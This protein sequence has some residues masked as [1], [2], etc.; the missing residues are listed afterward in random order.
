MMRDAFKNWASIDLEK[1]CTRITKGGTPTTYG[2]NFLKEGINFIKV[3]N[4]KNGAVDLKSITDFIS[5]EAHAYQKK[6]QLQSGDLLF[7][8][9]GTI[10]A[11]CI[12]KEEIL[13]ANTNQALAIIQGF[14]RTVS[15]NFLKL[16]LDSFI[17]RKVTSKARG[18]AM[19]NVS[20]G[21]LKKLEVLIPPLPEQRAIVAKI[22]KLFSD[23]DNGIANLKAAKVKLDIYRQAVLKKAF[24]GGFN[25][26]SID[27]EEKKLGDILKISSGNGLTKAGRDD[28]G[29]YS[30]YGGNGITGRH[31]EY[32]FEKPQLIIGR[33]G[34]HCGNTHIT[35]PQSWV[36]DNAFVVYFNEN[37]ISTKCLYYLILSLRLNQYASSTAQP[38]ISGGKL[39]PVRF[40]FPP[41]KTQDSLIEAIESRLSVCD[42]LA[43]SIDQS[44]EK[45]EAL[46]QSILK[47]AFAGQLLN[48][49]ELAACRREPDWEPAHKLLER[50][51]KNKSVGAKNATTG[52]SRKA[53]KP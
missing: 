5:E 44:L 19:N 30:V 52:K 42:K 11:T 21:D 36:T 24:E 53:N 45:S 47:K 22:D 3:E 34:V 40:L 43:E 29:E 6:S 31:S 2:Y 25:G 39:Y 16:Q 33:V 38:V 27:W 9:A 12:V 32:M 1:L 50:I 23:L 10:G 51:K 41:K 4:I 28:N 7:S 8:I 48:E 46:R 17:A 26:G 15:P 37:E 49:A 14:H 20:L 18:G 13:P 35:K